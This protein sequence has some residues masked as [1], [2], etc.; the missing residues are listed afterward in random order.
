MSNHLSPAT[1]ARYRQ[2]QLSPEALLAMDEHLSGC[3]PCR[4]QLAAN[5]ESQESYQTLRQELETPLPHLTDRQFVVLAAGKLSGN[6]VEAVTSHLEECDKCQTEAKHLSEYAA[7]RNALPRQRY[8]P[9]SARQPTRTESSR[10]NFV[11]NHPPQK[12][13]WFPNWSANFQVWKAATVMLLLSGSLIISYLSYRH[14]ASPTVQ[15]TTRDA[16]SPGQT[17]I[18]PLTLVWESEGL[19]LVGEKVAGKVYYKICVS[20]PGKNNLC[21]NPDSQVPAT[22]PEIFLNNNE[23]ENQQE[24]EVV[25]TAHDQ[26]TNDL[27]DSYNKTIIRVQNRWQEVSTRGKR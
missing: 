3:E 27:L 4:Q 19:K 2:R 25:I 24:L 15:I 21:V 10:E 11:P 1:V 22:Q 16:S 17:Q 26:T 8:Q 9:I 7:R 20:V 5:S 12:K 18:L 13:R 14:P 23:L 6:E